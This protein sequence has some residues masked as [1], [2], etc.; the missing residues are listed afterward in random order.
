MR[1]PWNLLERARAHESEANERAGH[2]PPSGTRSR[3]SRLE[4]AVTAALVASVCAGCS[5]SDRCTLDTVSVDSSGTVTR[6][7][8]SRTISSMQSDEEP[9]SLPDIRDAVNDAS[10]ATGDL[11]WMGTFGGGSFAIALRLPVSNLTTI[12]LAAEPAESGGS[13][14]FRGAGELTGTAGAA[15]ILQL[16]PP[17]SAFHATSVNG[18]V[19][20]QGVKPLAF[21]IVAE[22]TSNAIVPVETVA[23]DASVRFTLSDRHDPNCN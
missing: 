21:R 12:P 17:P 6:G 5:D 13:Q 18:S 22:Y 15:S 11:L 9:F 23:L 14:D 16:D 7:G 10:E 3:R 19:S 8:M 1:S 2:Q 20:I 4:A